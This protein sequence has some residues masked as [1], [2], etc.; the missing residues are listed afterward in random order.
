M[1]RFA[2]ILL[3]SAWP[4]LRADVSSCAC[5]P[6]NPESLKARQCSLCKE[7]LK[8][9]PGEEFFVLKDIN[10]RKPNRWL[11]LPVAHGTAQHHFRDLPKPQRDK[12]WRE[13]I[14]V[15]REKFGD[16][17][18]LAYNGERARTQCHLHL[19]IGRFIPAAETSSGILVRRIE[20]IPA[21]EEGGIWVHPV[22][23]GF[24]VHLGDQIAET[25]LVR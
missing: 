24:H 1:R 7:A 9:P 18:G 5:D 19:H 22:P 23:G 25:A 21:P 13:A 10:P 17:W 20:D 3:L 2:L 14:R 16:A 4:A 11:I 6:K 8:R 15:A 12:L